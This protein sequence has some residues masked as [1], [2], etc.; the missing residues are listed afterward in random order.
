M[1]KWLAVLAAVIPLAACQDNQAENGQTVPWVKTQAVAGGHGLDLALTGS[2]RAQY[3]TPVA[4][5][6]PGQI[7]SRSVDAGQSVKKDQVLFR[8]DASDNTAQLASAT[9]NLATAQTARDIARHDADRQRELFAKGF[10]SKQFLERAELSEREADARYN[11]AHAQWKQAKNASQYNVLRAPFDGVVVE[12]SGEPGQVVA[13]GAAVAV[14]AQ[15]GD[16]EVDVSF[17]DRLQA[18]KEGRLLLNETESVALRLRE[19]SGALDPVSRTWRARYVL[20]DPS[21][22]PPL[23]AVVS[24]RF[25]MP[26]VAAG[27]IEVPLGALD[28]R[29]NGPQVWR[30][31]EGKAQ[32]LPVKI[33]LLGS[34]SARIAANLPANTKLIVLGTHLLKPGMVVQELAQ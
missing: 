19:V 28:E 24:T 17:P 29:G 10:V 25:A 31:I 5:R 18:P 3:E 6:I 1:Y 26:Q 2:I 20:A 33:V 9:A 34:E 7:I 14:I 23:G 21:K 32:P 22:A 12:L 8:Q 16:R 30:I 11:A 15:N 13:A 27:A 4:F